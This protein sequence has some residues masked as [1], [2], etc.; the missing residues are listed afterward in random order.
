MKWNHFDPNC[1]PQGKGVIPSKVVMNLKLDEQGRTAQHMAPLFENVY[2]HKDA[3]EYRNTLA[4]AIPFDV[5]LLTVRKHPS[6]VLRVPRADIYTAFLDEDIHGELNSQWDSK[7]SNLQ[8]GLY[9]LKQ[10]L[11]L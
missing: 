9:G 6:L 4:A 8:K 7:C 10:S 1:V 5:L 3:V 2:G 11:N